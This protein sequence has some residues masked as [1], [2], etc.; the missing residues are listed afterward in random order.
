[1]KTANH[2]KTEI[3]QQ[4][5]AECWWEGSICTDVP[6]TSTSHVVSQHG[7]IRSIAFRAALMISKLQILLEYAESYWIHVIETISK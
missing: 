3:K 2:Q 4:N 7:K 5:V 1:V 6:P